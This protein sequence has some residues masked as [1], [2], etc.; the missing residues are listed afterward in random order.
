MRNEGF[1]RLLSAVHINKRSLFFGFVAWFFTI[2][3]FLADFR[4]RIS[5]QMIIKS[6]YSKTNIFSNVLDFSSVISD[7]TNL[8]EL[9]ILAMS[10]ERSHISFHHWVHSI[11]VWSGLEL[12]FGEV[13]FNEISCVVRGVVHVKFENGLVFFRHFAMEVVYDLLD[14]L[15]LVL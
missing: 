2:F 13:L 14:Q 1:E 5:S 10:L 9:E 4:G 8:E 3:I 15:E 7:D 11:G 12:G 6:T